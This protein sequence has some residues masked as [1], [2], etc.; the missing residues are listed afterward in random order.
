MLVEVQTDEISAA[1]SLWEIA[2]LLP[3]RSMDNCG[4]LVVLPPEHTGGEKLVAVAI[5]LTACQAYMVRSTA[6]TLSAI[7]LSAHFLLS[8]SSISY[9]YATAPCQLQTFFSFTQ[10]IY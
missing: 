2:W 8:S 7:V 3:W 10:W 1:G 5:S 9:C 6:A 4:V